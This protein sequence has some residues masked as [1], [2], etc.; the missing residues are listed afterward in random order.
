MNWDKSRKKSSPKNLQRL[1]NQNAFT[2]LAALICFILVFYAFSNKF[3][4]ISAQ[5]AFTEKQAI[6]IALMV[7]ERESG[8][9]ACERVETLLKSILV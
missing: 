4:T 2:V 9:S 6:H 7:V 1:S 8:I 3:V 5:Q